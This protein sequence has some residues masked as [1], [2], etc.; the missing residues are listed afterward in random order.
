[1]QVEI[2]KIIF[3]GRCTKDS[4]C[5]ILKCNDTCTNS[6]LTVANVLILYCVYTVCTGTVL[7][8]LILYCVCIDTV[9]YV[10]YVLYIDTVLCVY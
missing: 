3:I 8:V 5:I 4:N 10:L 6:I 2:S 9:L 7:C 1:M